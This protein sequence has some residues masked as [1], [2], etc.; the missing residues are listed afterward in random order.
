M[1]F[2]I[3]NMF[4]IIF[5]NSFSFPCEWDGYHWQSTLSGRQFSHSSVWAL[6]YVILLNCISGE[7]IPTTPAWRLTKVHLDPIVSIWHVQFVAHRPTAV[8]D[9]TEWRETVLGYINTKCVII[10]YN[11]VDKYKEQN[12]LFLSIFY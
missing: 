1:A 11:T 12:M 3:G 9:H 4:L 2:Q 6:R 10:I 5:W 7:F 8:L